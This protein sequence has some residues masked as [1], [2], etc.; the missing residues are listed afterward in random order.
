MSVALWGDTS[1]LSKV[2]L[3][4]VPQYP[5][6]CEPLVTS[7]RREALPQFRSWSRGLE[8]D[9]FVRLKAWHP[10]LAEQVKVSGLPERTL[11]R[12]L[13]ALGNHRELLTTRPMDQEAEPEKSCP[14]LRDVQAG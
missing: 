6:R 5:T 12:K 13:K 8:L 11:H 10:T 4:D 1:V 14:G 2:V 9:Y 7:S 3:P